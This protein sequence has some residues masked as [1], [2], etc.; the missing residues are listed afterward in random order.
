MRV[1]DHVLIP[2]RDGTRL[3]ARIWLPPDASADNP[4]P[5]LLEYLPYRKADWTAPRDAQRHPWYAEHGY[6]SV[7][8]D[9]RGSGDSGG[10]MTDEYSPAELSDGVEVIEWLAGQPWCTGKVGMFGISWGGFNSLQVAALRPPAL[11]A[12]VTVCSTDDRYADDVH[13]FGGAVLGVDMLGWSMTMLATTALPPDPIRVPDWRAQWDQRLSELVPFVDTWLAH[14]ERDDYWRHGS[15]CEDYQAIDAAVL[16]VGGWADPYRNTVLRLLP[17]LSA[18]AKGLIG[19]WAHQYPDIDRPPGPHIGF[20]Q[21]T[22]RWW[23][24]WLRDVPNGAESGPALRAW[25]QDSVPPATAYPERPGRWVTEPSWPS[26][27]VSDTRYPLNRLA[28]G[29]R[30]SVTVR[31]PQHTGIDAGRFFPYGNPADL[32]PDQ[33][34]EDGRSITF[35]TGE[36]AEPVEVLGHPRARLRLRAGASGNVIVRLCDIAPDGSS[37]LVTRGC[38][39]LARRDGMSRSVPPLEV[40]ETVEISMSAIAW[41]FPP[42]HRIRLAVSDAYW[43]WVWP[44]PYGG[45]PLVL[46][47]GDSELIVPVRAPGAPSEPVRFE[48]PEHAPPLEVAT[49]DPPGEPSPEREVRYF[50]QAGEWR[51]SVNPQY[52]GT[53]T[54]PDG[55]RKS[56]EALETYSIRDG[57]PLSAVAESDWRISLSRPGW[58]VEVAAHGRMTADA[59]NFHTT[60][61]VRATLDGTAVFDQ[62]WRSSIPRASA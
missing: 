52:A 29:R 26:P 30:K 50:P 44:Q 48:P 36:L 37:T 20:L 34:A 28:G 18:P 25:M 32:P 8:V 53:R 19:P 43:P 21:E 24:R 4:V 12:I 59:E 13:Y 39:N 7:R 9:L 40:D 54:F 56:E 5:A 62:S 58:D 22:L 46:E 23:D 45:D 55:L 33:R 11:K 47:P 1:L 3:S 15:V 38:L 41:V 17:G 14:Q 35:S 42:G 61:T 27:N 16:A 49:E 60:H 10:V 6:A 31:A 57:D 51:L 2:T